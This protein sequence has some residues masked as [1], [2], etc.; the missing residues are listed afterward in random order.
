MYETAGDEEMTDDDYRIDC[1]NDECCWTGLASQCVTLKH[2]T[3][4]L[5]PECYDT[6]EPVADYED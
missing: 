3:D 6:T 5:C 4:L 1:T 2:G